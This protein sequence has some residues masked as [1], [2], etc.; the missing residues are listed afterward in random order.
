MP[1]PWNA[2]FDFAQDERIQAARLDVFD[3]PPVQL[4]PAIPEE[5]EG[6]A[7]LF[8]LSGVDGRHQHARL[9][10]SELRQHI[11][12][13]IAD[14]AVAVEALA[15]LGTMR[16]AATTGTTLDTAWPTI[17]RRQSRDVSRSG[18]WGSDPIAVG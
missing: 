12:A 5:A 15:A 8:R 6:S 4:R 1:R 11:A 10:R 13:L 16:L 2:P 9:L 18:S 14:E 3:Q 17:A 7:M